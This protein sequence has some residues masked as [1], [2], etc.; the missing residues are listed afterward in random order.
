MGSMRGDVLRDGSGCCPLGAAFDLWPSIGPSS[1][2]L[3]AIRV[4]HA[5]GPYSV[6]IHLVGA[7]GPKE[8]EAYR[9]ADRFLADWDGGLITDLADALGVQERRRLYGPIPWRSSPPGRSTK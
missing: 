4:G 1:A 6:A 8:L 3:D 9:A 2:P 7:S 5:P